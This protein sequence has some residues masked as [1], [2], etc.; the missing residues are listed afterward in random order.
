VDNRRVEI[1]AVMKMLN[2]IDARIDENSL[3]IGGNGRVS[4]SV[5][6]LPKEFR[7]LS[8]GFSSLVKLMQ[9]IIAGYS[10]FTNEANLRAVRGVVFIDEIESHLHAQWQARIIP[11]LKAMLPNTTFYVATH[12][13][14][15]LLRLEEG[16]AYLL[17]RSSDGAV[18]TE[19][20]DSPARRAF[21]DVIEST[22]ELD[23]NEIK[24][25]T[26]L[27]GDQSEVKAKILDLLQ[28]GDSR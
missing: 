15:V 25:N 23:L 13:P 26:L 22:F 7:H 4:I 17:L 5:D 20:I 18:K 14:L 3:Q 6:G 19:K 27:L 16:E 21:S 1:E 9:E 12:S 24:K 2:V 28:R 11:A 10:A 8:S